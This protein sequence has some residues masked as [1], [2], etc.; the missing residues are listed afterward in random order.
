MRPAR[1][2][3]PSTLRKTPASIAIAQNMKMV[4]GTS[5][6]ADCAGSRERQATEIEVTEIDAVLRSGGHV[7]CVLHMIKMRREGFWMVTTDRISDESSKVRPLKP[8][9]E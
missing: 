8:R 4:S 6:V 7:S 5:N 9:G 3:N 2:S 1:P